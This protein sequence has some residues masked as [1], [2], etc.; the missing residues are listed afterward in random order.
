MK[1]GFIVN[2]IAG[3]GGRVGLKGTDGPEILEKAR[4]LGAVPES[5]DKA[6]KALTSLLPLI[7]KLQIYTYG[8]SMGEEEA[9]SLGF[10]PIILGDINNSSGPESTEEA[11]KRMA[12]IG[13]DLI[14]FAG[15]DGT[16]RNIYN[17]IGAE[18]P[19]IG[20]PAGVKI[21]SAVYA[22]HPKAAGEIALKY[23][24]DKS[25][26]TK[27]AEVMDIDEKSFREG[28]VTARL[29]GY[30]QIPIEPELIQTTKSGGLGSEEDAL[31]GIA[32]RIVDDMEEGVFYIVGSGTSTRPIMERLGL[33]NTLLGIDIVKNKALV[34]SDVNEKEIL[35][36]IED[37][38]AKII[39]TV[40]GGQGYIFGRGNQQISAEVIKKVGK[41][42]IQ[43]IATKNKLLSLKGRPLLVDTGNE[44]VNSMF[45]GYMKVLISS[46]METVER[47]EGL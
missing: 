25:I 47:V 14:L 17:A 37:N 40:I 30:M 46:Y 32:E 36:I 42:N 6:K 8:G 5:P 28:I 22:S 23:L 13:V 3:M 9:V 41:D 29:Y 4:Q 10:N 45:K 35:E 11:A 26:G 7:D 34:A 24:R 12:E 38:R 39:V 16:A 43:I 21:H 31:E 27:E 44:E 1:L 19:V 18:V 2:P 33:P 20:I 15:G